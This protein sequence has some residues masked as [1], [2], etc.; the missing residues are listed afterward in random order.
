MALSKEIYK[1]FEDVLGEENISDDPNVLESYKFKMVTVVM[2]G[3]TEEVQAVV[4]L[5]NKYRLPI[6][7]GS[8]GWTGLITNKTESVFIDLKRM[9]RILEINEKQQY[10]VVEPGVISGQLQAEL[11]KRGL[12]CGI[13]GCGSTATALAMAGHGHMGLT[14]STG[15]RNTL[16][17]EWVTDEGDI[18]R[19][20][21]LGSVNDWFCGDGPGPSLRGILQTGGVITKQAL[22]VYH[23][24]GPE[25]FPIVGT[26]PRYTFSEIPSNLFV[27]YYSFP[28]AEQWLEAE[29]KIGKAEVA[30][31]M[32]GFN[33]MMLASNIG[34]SKEEELELFKVIKPQLQGPGFVLI[35]GGNYPEDFQ[36]KK[37]VV[38]KIIQE[39]EGKSLALAEQLDIAGILLSSC[40]R[41]SA[42]I[43]ETSRNGAGNTGSAGMVVEGQRYDLH[44]KWLEISAREKREFIKK[45]L[46]NDDGGQQFGWG[47][48]GCHTGHS[49]LFC[50]FNP[51][52]PEAVVAVA[53]YRKRLV[54]NALDNFITAPAMGASMEQ[55]GPRTS[56]FH[57]W[58]GK[59]KQVFDPNG[60]GENT[61]FTWVAWPLPWE[62]YPAAKK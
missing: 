12:N 58:E 32:M 62:S 26:S 55:L 5:C 48:E 16:A 11:M 39:T 33:A 35:I 43:R 44:V 4:R 45:G 8:T 54:N 14:T 19:L 6:K 36:Y 13:K 22:K 1:E 53:E 18:I 56:N 37:M 51:D 38:E 49:E 2:P 57:L 23:W 25:R 40:I 50:R 29:L 41:I 7:V 9:N 3:N 34:T 42:S 52:N 59:V 61:G 24:P 46:V 27:R 47:D 30:Y 60:V 15:D 20:G 21:S 17:T 28:T 31:L 10:A